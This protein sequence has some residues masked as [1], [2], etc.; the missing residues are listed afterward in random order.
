LEISETDALI[1]G[2]FE[3]MLL[4]LSPPIEESEGSRRSSV[5]IGAVATSSLS[6]LSLKHFLELKRESLGESNLVSSSLYRRRAGLP[7]WAPPPGAILLDTLDI[8]FFSKLNLFASQNEETK[9]LNSEVDRD[10]GLRY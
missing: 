4:P 6:L 9:S 10:A 3:S 5:N 2:S 1:R 8:A 7:T